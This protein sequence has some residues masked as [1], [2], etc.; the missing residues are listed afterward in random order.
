MVLL[1]EI[2]QVPAAEAPAK[3]SEQSDHRPTPTQQNIQLCIH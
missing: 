1:N 2:L 3:F